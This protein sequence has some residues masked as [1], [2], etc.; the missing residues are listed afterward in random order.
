MLLGEALDGLGRTTEAISEFKAATKAAPREANLNFGLGYLYWKLRQYD[1]ALPA[2]E[3]ELS[4]DP[5]NPQA[6]AYLGD[7]EMRRNDPEKAVALLK[8][9]LEIKDDIRIAYADLGAIYMDERHYEDALAA[10]RRA[11]KLDPAQP[12]THFRL[13][14]LHQ[15]MGNTAAAQQEFAR[16][17]E[18]HKKTEGDLLEKM[19]GSPPPLQP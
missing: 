19:S 15:A 14:R 1:E 12:D 18:L 17:R 4:V 10:L 3:T 9:A 11:V 13:G 8:K 16:V 5:A 6:L 2:F 7:I